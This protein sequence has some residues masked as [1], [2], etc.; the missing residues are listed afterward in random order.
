MPNIDLTLLTRDLSGMFAG[1]EATNNLIH[2][3]NASLGLLFG[4]KIHGFNDALA[5]MSHLASNDA[6]LLTAMVTPFVLAAVKHAATEAGPLEAASLGTVVDSQAL[7][8]KERI[9]EKLLGTLGI[10]G[11]ATWLGSESSDVRDEVHA[12]GAGAGAKQAGVA[13]EREVAR[14]KPK[15]PWLV[16]LLLAL[17]ALLSLGFCM[18]RTPDATQPPEATASAPGV[19]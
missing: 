7:H 2:S 18:K 8:V 16:L 10:G 17:L 6:A 14:R 5:G 4:Q 3:G 15:W 19:A 11:I 13:T 12:I 9:S 1:G